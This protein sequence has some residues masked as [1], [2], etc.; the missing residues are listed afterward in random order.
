M[1]ITAKAIRQ[2]FDAILYFLPKSFKESKEP[3]INQQAKTGIP[4]DVS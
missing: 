3:V 1:S 4:C 2:L